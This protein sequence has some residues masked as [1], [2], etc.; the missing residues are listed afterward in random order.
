MEEAGMRVVGYVRVSSRNAEQQRESEA[1]QR[2]AIRAWCKANG[3]R[4]VE[5]YRDVGVSGANGLA[6]REGL[7][8]AE[9]AIVAGKADGLVVRELDR[10]HRDVMVQENVFADL[11]RIRPTVEVFSTKGGEQQNCRRDDPE[12][13]S[14]RLIR[15]VLGAVADYVRVQTVARLRA[16]KRRKAEAGGYVGGQPAY[17]TRA[18]D[19]ALVLDPAEQAAIARI[20]ELHRG[21]A[22][23]RAIAAALA[24]EGHRPK[25]GDRWH[26]QTVARVLGRL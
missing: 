21:G 3:H 10:L 4:L 5:V 23:L 14:R 1:E 24:A 11:W 9:A 13:P 18:E 15:H 12:D 8:D 16:G 2:R 6:Q 20:A 22:S 26:P 7:P 19:K 17:G 25:R